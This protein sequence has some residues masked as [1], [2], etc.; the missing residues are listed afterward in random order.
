VDE[1]FQPFRGEVAEFRA[2]LYEIPFYSLFLNAFYSPNFM[3][4]GKTFKKV[5]KN[6][7][8]IKMGKVA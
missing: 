7:C 5:R 1:N 4:A 2:K 8:E 3:S 6:R